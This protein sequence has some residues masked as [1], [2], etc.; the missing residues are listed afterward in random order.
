MERLG[1]RRSR[2]DGRHSFGNRL[3]SLSASALRPSLNCCRQCHPPSDSRPYLIFRPG[4]E[5]RIFL[6]D[7]CLDRLDIP[8]YVN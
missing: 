4:S 6:P 8:K 3:E 1:N 7:G 5:M 2:G